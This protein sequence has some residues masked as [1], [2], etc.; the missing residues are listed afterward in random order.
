LIR[1][2]IKSLQKTIE[3]TSQEAGSICFFDQLDSRERG[4]FLRPAT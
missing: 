2:P 1:L 4:D 3:P